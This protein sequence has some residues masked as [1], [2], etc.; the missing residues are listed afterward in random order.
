MIVELNVYIC[1]K[2]HKMRIVGNIEHPHCKI[3]IF[4][5][6]SRFL[7]KFESGLYEQAY[8][9][10]IG[11]TINSVEDVRYFVDPDFV[12]QVI[13]H[14]N[15]MHLEASKAMARFTENVEEPEEFDVI[16]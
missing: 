12:R 11:D 1:A 16:I 6:E 2:A 5:T 7:V 10:R 4:K 9:F 13:K 14:F 3:T 8:R 15:S